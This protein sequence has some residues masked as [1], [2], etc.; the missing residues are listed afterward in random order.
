M[1]IL[2]LIAGAGD[3]FC[4]SCLRDNSLA[5]ALRKLGHDAVLIPLYT[6]VRTDGVNY[7]QRRIFFGGI[8]IYLEQLSG[9]FRRLPKSFDR[10]WD[11][12]SVIKAFTGRGVEVDPKQL[13]ELTVSMLRGE[14]G[15][16]RKEIEHLAA[17]L[18]HEP[19]FQLAVIPYTLLIGLAKPL[20]QAIRAP[21]LCGLQGEEFFL[22]NLREPYRTE[23]LSLIRRQVRDVDAFIAVSHYGKRHM[24]QYLHIP[25]ERIHVVP[26]GVDVSGCESPAP[27]P[28]GPPRIGFFS[29]IAPEKG[30]HLL[31]D[32][33]IQLRKSGQLPEARLE[34]AGY[35]SP[36]HKRYLTEQET[37]LA[38]AGFYSEFRYRGAPERPGKLEFLRSLDFLVMPA[39][40]D[41]P[42]G[43]PLLEALA[44]GTPVIAPDRGSF[45]EMSEATGGVLLIEKDSPAALAEAIRSL[46]RNRHFAGQLA[47]AGYE[48]VHRGWTLQHMAQRTVEVYSQLIR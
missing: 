36:A 5:G 44:A 43:I 48:S 42:K 6:P 21:I 26:L 7:S 24:S 35:L 40:F 28:S 25:E 46:A 38:K 33:Y 9:F 30:L 29:R 32:A 3:M 27:R 11:S 37:K 14:L 10:F 2:S 13:G 18:R 39:A 22:D 8:S 16:Q 47:E 17:W 45:R 19:P 41:E 20:R 12:P 4:G 31:V 1:R 23:A 34:A 15:N